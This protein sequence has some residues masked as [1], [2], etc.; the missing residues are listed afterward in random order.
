MNNDELLSLKE[1]AEILNVTTDE[2]ARLIDTGHIKA[3][4]VNGKRK[5]WKSDIPSLPSTQDHQLDLK[6]AAI[7]VGES[8]ETLKEF[9]KKGWLR[10]SNQHGNYTFLFKDLYKYLH[11]TKKLKT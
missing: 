6:L 1:V 2:V 10:G 4:P 7:Y 3:E 11:F 5:V 8:E 9:F